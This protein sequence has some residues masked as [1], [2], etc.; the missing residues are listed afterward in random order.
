MSHGYALAFDL[1][2]TTLAARLV[3]G[4]GTCVAQAG[5]YNPQ[6]PFGAD[7]IRRMENAVAGQ[8]EVL[9]QLLQQALV[10]LAGELVT[11]AGLTLGDVGSV[12]AAGNPAISLLLQGADV[13]SLLRPPYRPT[14]KEGLV[15]AVPGLPVPLYLMPLVSGF[16]GGDLV[17]VLYGVEAPIAG[18]LFIDVGT[19]GEMALFDG[20]SW[21]VT[22]VAAG[23]AFEGGQVA[24]GMPAVAGAVRRVHLEQDQLRLEVIGDLPPRGL[25]GS[26][27]VTAIAAA[28]EGGL[29]DDAGTLVDPDEVTTNLVRYLMEEKGQRSLCLYRDARVRL[30][31]SQEEI[32]QFQLA[33]GAVY[34][35][36]QCLL[37]RAELP[38]DALQQVVL[39]GALG[40]SLPAEALKSVALLPEYMIKKV[41]FMRDGVLA[42]L[43]R[44]LLQPDAA[45]EVGRLVGAMRSYPLSGT[46]RFERAFVRALNFNV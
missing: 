46:P 29:L 33:K 23:P 26:G 22:S 28:R 16:V 5:R 20:Q 38:P 25:C 36:A 30:C 40:F 37:E 45:A 34:A 8:G 41:I 24:C 32:R 21:W 4:Q 11:Q 43:T 39:T 1:G 7:V 10:E 14:V 19:N 44:F 35:G 9:Q 6:I 18:S 31:L 3:D 17:S 15:L 2:T 42:G 12:V 13:Q 27:L